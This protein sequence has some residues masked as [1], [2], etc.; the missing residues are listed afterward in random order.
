MASVK[1][2]VYNNETTSFA[3]NWHFVCG[4]QNL[5]FVQFS[6][7]VVERRS[8]QIVEKLSKTIG[9]FP[10][11]ILQPYPVKSLYVRLTLQSV[12]QFWQPCLALLSP[13][14]VTETEIRHH[15]FWRL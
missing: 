11:D 3:N 5:C 10:L 12:S 14:W 1:Y 8:A 13:F 6:V 9:F 4:Y 7:V 15:K 2:E